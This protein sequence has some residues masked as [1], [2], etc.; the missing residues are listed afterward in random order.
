M[1]HRANSQDCLVSDIIKI[2]IQ[3]TNS[4]ILSPYLCY[5]ST[6]E[7]LHVLTYPENSLWV[8]ISQILMTSG[9]EK[10]II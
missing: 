3:L 8:I 1:Y 2:S 5:K 6:G 9:G 7:K 4:P 10:A